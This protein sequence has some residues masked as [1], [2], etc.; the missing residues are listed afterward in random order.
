MLSPI[1]NAKDLPMFM[2]D[3]G[4]G[5][6]VDDPRFQ[7]PPVYLVGWGTNGGIDTGDTP[8]AVKP[9]LEQA[10]SKFTAEELGEIFQKYGGDAVVCNDYQQ[11]VDHP[12][13][14]AINLF[15]E[16][17]DPVLGRIRFQRVPWSLDGVPEPAPTCFREVD[18]A[19][20]R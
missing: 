2:R 4:M 19:T 9:I 16:L 13:I 14:Q 20:R 5:E 11:F 7:H 6:Y 15:G 10:F 3:L 18:P 12:Q 1:S 8:M 17:G